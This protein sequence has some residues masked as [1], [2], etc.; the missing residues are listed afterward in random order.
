[1]ENI[2][3]RFTTQLERLGYSET[4]LYMLPRCVQ[5]FLEVQQVE[6]LTLIA[7]EQIQKHYEH[8]QQRPNKMKPGG[9]S[10]SHIGHHIY[11]LK[12]FFKWLE[13]TGQITANPISPLNF[14][15]PKQK[16]RETLTPQEI[17]TLY[18]TCE[19]Y[20]ERAL[21]SLYY[22]C[23][24][25]RTEGVR[26]DVKDLHFRNGLLYVREGKGA[27]RRVVPM[28][29]QVQTDLQAYAQRERKAK[30]GETAFLTGRTGARTKGGHLNKILKSLLAKAG[31]NKEISLHSLRHSIATHLLEAGLSVE[32]VRDFLGHSH[33][34]STQIYTRVSKQQLGKL[35]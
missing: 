32:D 28:S 35:A 11:A 1:M 26:L 17:K 25:R 15:S 19:N 31:I 18:E 4:S 13:E 9:L 5:E 2:I 23:G 7:A 3:K 34:E 6:S 12:T 16:E 24:L 10:E 22:G 20:R 29:K 8:L 30:P 27:K 21:L 33:L 14:P